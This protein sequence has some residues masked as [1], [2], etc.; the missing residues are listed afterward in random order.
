[1]YCALLGR[2]NLL[3]VDS[4][5]TGASTPLDCPA[6]QNFAGSTATGA[7]QRTVA[8]GA[9]PLNHRW[10]YANGR[11]VHASDLFDT[12]AAVDDLAAVI[13]ALG[14]GKVDL[15]G[16]SGAMRARASADARP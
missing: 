13:D 1:M 4:R 7:F 11:C 5:G 8:A 6:L 3:A 9:Q 15:Y 16:D 10:R 12:T 2:W 14:L